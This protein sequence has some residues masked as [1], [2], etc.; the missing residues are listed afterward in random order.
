MSSGAVAGGAPAFHASRSSFDA[1]PRGVVLVTGAAGYIGSHVV[2]ALVED[3]W[4]VVALDDLSTGAAISLPQEVPL[5]R[6]DI[7]NVEILAEIF[8]R[9]QIFGVVHLA[10]VS[11]VPDAAMDPQRCQDINVAGTQALLAAA[12]AAGVKGFLLSST[13][14]VY[15]ERATAPFSE[16]AP[17][18]PANVYGES[19][20]AAERALSA[21]AINGISLRYFNV[22]GAD[23]DSGMGDRRS[24][25]SHLIK[26]ALECATGRRRGLEIFGEDYPTPDGSCVRDYVH[27]TDVAR[28]HSLAMRH[29][30]AGK[31]G[32]AFNIGSGR[33]FSVK[34]VVSAVQ[35]ISGVEFPVRTVARRPGDPALLCADVRKSQKVMQFVPARS[36]L[37]TIIADAWRWEQILA[38]TRT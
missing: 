23:P 9:D 4:R 28:A 12:Q 3:R 21:S 31:P 1:A 30:L 16:D 8:G 6:S 10:A 26:V 37:E 38:R 20:L 18:R 36:A 13:A 35:R 14:A 29:L 5:V 34:E 22:A 24:H 2:A 33:G 32:E 11:S 25:S 15:D 27:V 17:L 19:K 7:R